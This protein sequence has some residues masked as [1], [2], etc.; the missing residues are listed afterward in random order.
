MFQIPYGIQSSTTAII[1]A[2]IGAGRVNT[3][4]RYYKSIQVLGLFVNG[5][6]LSLQFVFRRQILSIFTN[7]EEII[8]I[9]ADMMWFSII[10]NGLDFQQGLLYGVIKALVKQKC[11]AILNFIS[12]NVLALPLSYLCAF[13]F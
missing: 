9:G 11:A 13:H 2:E 7:N 8:N 4:K 10:V 1:G 3:A 12:C 5:L 6:M